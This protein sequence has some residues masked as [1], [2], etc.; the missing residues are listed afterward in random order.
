VNPATGQTIRS[1][2]ETTDRDLDEALRTGDMAFGEWRRTPWVLRQDLLTR[3][4]VLLR[5]SAASHARLMADE[6][7]KPLA[8]GLAETDKCA[9]ACEYFANHAEEFLRDRPAVSDA[10]VS[11]VTFQPLGVLLA[12]MPWNF[13]YWQVF[14]CAAPALMAGN[15]VLL[16]H[17][18]NV[19]GCALEIERVF[20]EAGLPH[21][22]FRTVLVSASRIGAV[23]EHP[24]IKAVTLTGSVPAGRAIAALAGAALKKTVLELG[25]SDPYVVLEDADLETAVDACVTSRLTNSGQ[26]CI[27]AKRF[28]VVEAVADAFE[29]QFVE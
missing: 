17:A 8:Q 19:S 22:A 20:R 18:S 1:Y 15:V 16:K 6:M 24:A 28:I 27:A 26:S 7:G 4:A 9:L 25:G 21:G 5:E 3:V 11:F 29:R 14:R 13:P 12:V 2:S 10:S 23:I